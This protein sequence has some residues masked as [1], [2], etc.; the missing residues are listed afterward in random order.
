MAKIPEINKKNFKKLLRELDLS[1]FPSIKTDNYLFNIKIKLEDKI[2]LSIA[3]EL[4]CFPRFKKYL[5]GLRKE[6][7]KYYIDNINFD[8]FSHRP[9]K[10]YQKEGVIWL[11]ERDRCILADD[12]GLGK[13]LEVILASLCL[14]E[15]FKV[16]IITKKMLKYNFEK[17]L[18]FYSDSCKVIEDKWETG[19]KFTIINYEAL[20]KFKSQII[21]E[22]FQIIIVDECHRLINTKAKT[23]INFKNIISDNEN[24]IKKIWLLTGTPVNNRPSDLYSL[25]SIIKHPIATNWQKYVE[26][27]CD[28]WKDENDRWNIKGAS[29]LEELHLKTK[30]SI[31]R[32][33]KKDYLPDLPNKYRQ[34]IWLHLEN[35][36]GYDSVVR[37]YKEKKLEEFNE[38]PTIANLLSAKL[39]TPAEITK[40]ILERQFCALEKIKDGSLINLLKESIEEGNKIVL[41]TNFTEV[42]DSVY[43]YFTSGI[44]RFIDGRIKDAKKRF[45]IIE[46]FNN[47]DSLKLLILNMVVGNAG[48]NIQSANIVLV[49]DLNWVPGAMIQ[50]ED[51]TWRLGQLK[52]VLVKYLIYRNTI[53]EVLFNTVNEKTKNISTTVEGEQ[54]IFFLNENKKK[55]NNLEQTDEERRQLLLNEIFSKL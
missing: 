54:E 41:F 15:Y 43:N 48:S 16:L 32:R 17:E 52:D 49:N 2:H 44:S 5:E 7:N 10:P 50:A 53:E 26:R 55:E 33:L 3:E 51:R 42:I 37:K 6:E 31:L 12:T 29:N 39:F 1:S 24:A 21:E 34:P 22:R 9:P 46:E 8:K 23:F 4:L 28:G 40:I 19:Y 47:D 27:Y 35:R 30:D 45:S 14:Q 20:K 38:F 11:L 36:K 13:T 18:S 25:L